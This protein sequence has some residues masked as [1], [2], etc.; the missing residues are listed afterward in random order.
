MM[1]CRE[2]AENSNMEA[3]AISYAKKAINIYLGKPATI[4]YELNSVENIYG[5]RWKVLGEVSY[6]GH[7]TYR[8]FEVELTLLKGGGADITK[9]DITI[10]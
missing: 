6:F 10:H 4:R 8:K 7:P 2:C 9:K 3:Y 5:D 1:N